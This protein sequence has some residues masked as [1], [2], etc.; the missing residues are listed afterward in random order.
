MYH[1]L[2]VS[3]LTP[4]LQW[5]NGWVLGIQSSISHHPVRSIL[6]LAIVVS[7]IIFGIKRVLVED[8][9]NTSVY[10]NSKSGGRLD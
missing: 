6:L 7:G 9:R 1:S 5:L 2:A 3:G 8:T 4:R 10:I